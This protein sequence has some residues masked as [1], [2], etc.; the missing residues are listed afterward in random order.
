MALECGFQKKVCDDKCALYV[1]G[2]KECAVM[3]MTVLLE[4]MH[5]MGVLAHDKWIKEDPYADFEGDALANALG[6]VADDEE[7]DDDDLVELKKTD[8][9]KK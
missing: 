5:N 4:G 8:K 7:D 3:S 6:D 1:K 2:R 9:K